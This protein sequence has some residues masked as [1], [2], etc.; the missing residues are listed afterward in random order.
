MLTEHI[1]RMTSKGQVT[2]P[3]DI[4]K[5]LGIQPGETIIFRIRDDRVEIDRAPMSLEESFGSVPSMN[6]PEDFAA[7]E[8]VAWEEHAL[9]VID[10][11][12]EE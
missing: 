7:M 3:V 6:Q 12:N 11:M 2:V 8:R 1:R 4:R 10:E 5:K 9:R